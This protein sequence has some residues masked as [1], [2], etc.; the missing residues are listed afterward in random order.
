[1]STATITNANVTDENLGY[2]PLDSSWRLDG[3]LYN[4]ACG[5]S[6]P[7]RGAMSCQRIC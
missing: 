5:P 6:N 3:Y 2:E 1:M 4:E 7:N